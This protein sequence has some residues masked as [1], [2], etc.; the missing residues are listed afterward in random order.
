MSEASR[1]DAYAQGDFWRGVGIVTLILVVLI[2]F[3]SA[4]S[5]GRYA[6]WVL[7]LGAA[8]H[9]ALQGTIIVINVLLGWTVIGWIV[10]MAMAYGSTKTP[11]P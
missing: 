1:K 5:S 7:L 4:H 6:A 10:A 9:T 8:L 11:T 2:T 3:G